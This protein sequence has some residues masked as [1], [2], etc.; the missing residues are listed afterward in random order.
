MNIKGTDPFLEVI[1]YL[2]TDPVEINTAYVEFKKLLFFCEIFLIF[3]IV[4]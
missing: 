1:F 3:V 4:F 2:W